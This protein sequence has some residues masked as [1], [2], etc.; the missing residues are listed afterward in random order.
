MASLAGAWVKLAL[1]AL[2]AEAAVI[3][4]LAKRANDSKNTEKRWQEL[5]RHTIDR[6]EDERRRAACELHDELAQR[7]ALLSVDI[8]RLQQT[9]NLETSS[10]ELEEISER[11]K[12]IAS[13]LSRTAH[14]LH[15]TTLDILGLVPALRRLCREFNEVKVTFAAA[16]IPAPVP[17]EIAACFYRVAQ[18]CLT[19]VARH[20]GAK[21]AQIS[22]QF[23]EGKLKMRVSD[24]GCGF[25]PRKFPEAR[26]L[27]IAIM[28]ERLRLI[29][30]CLAVQSAIFG[31]TQVEASARLRSSSADQQRL[32]VLPGREI[33]QPRERTER[34]L[35]A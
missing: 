29:H 30:G 20:S 27:G 7:L 10:S 13:H 2:A 32:T 16:N 4:V 15:S 26:T 9:L 19:N 18:D 5:F 23:S 34:Y 21:S 6:N 28:E 3:L 11:S 33:Q 1:A 25:D 24:D 14:R 31:G 35:A 8:D 17:K 22:L 12:Q